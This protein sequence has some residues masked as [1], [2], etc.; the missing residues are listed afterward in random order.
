MMMW[1][2]LNVYYG[3]WQCGVYGMCTVGSDDVVFTECVLC[4]LMIGYILNVYFGFWW[5]GMYTE[6]VLWAPTW[7]YIR[8]VYY[9]SDDV[10]YT[11]CVLWGLTMW[12]IW[13]VYCGVWR[14]GIY[15]MCIVGSNDVF[16]Y[17]VTNNIFVQ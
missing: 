3:V 7:W 17:I 10:V 13:N 6:S 5:S 8:N 11:E 16:N 12:Y 9:G 14:C 1:Y 2:I 15:G 4:V